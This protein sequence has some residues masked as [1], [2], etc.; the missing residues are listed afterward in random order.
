V[1]RQLH[2]LGGQT[3]I[4]PW[5]LLLERTKVDAVLRW[6]RVPPAELEDFTTSIRQLGRASP[7]I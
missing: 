4:G 7:C 5:F 1:V 3:R 2:G 6:A